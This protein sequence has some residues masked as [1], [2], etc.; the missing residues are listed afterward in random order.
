MERGTGSVGRFRAAHTAVKKP[1]W[2]CTA[3]NEGRYVPETNRRSPS[4]PA[5]LVAQRQWLVASG[6]R[7][8]GLAWFAHVEKSVNAGVAARISAAAAAIRYS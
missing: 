4:F 2:R 5:K 7:P 1:G 3:Q 6:E 8:M